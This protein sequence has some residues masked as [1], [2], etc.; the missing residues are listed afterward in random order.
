V[1]TPALMLPLGPW[2]DTPRTAVQRALTFGLAALG[3]G[4]QL[5]LVLSRWTEVIQRMG[6]H[7]ALLVSGFDF[8]FVPEKSPLVGSWR[9]LGNGAVDAWLWGIAR[10]SEAH[11]GA[12]GFALV[13]LLAWALVAG[14][15]GLRLFRSARR[16]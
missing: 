15:V 5:V 4:V 14:F 2:L 6:Y 1:V 12:P 7:K 16:A 10:G 13:L 11:A 3:L 9:A 8:L